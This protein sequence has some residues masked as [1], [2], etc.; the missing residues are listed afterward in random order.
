MINVVDQNDKPLYDKEFTFEYDGNTI[1]AV[2]DADGRITLQKV[3]NMVTVT[4]YQL[5]GEG[6]K[7]NVN[8]FVFNRSSRN[9]KIVIFVEPEPVPVVEPPKVEEPKV[10]NMRFKVIDEKGAVIKSAKVTI[11]YDGIKKELLTDSDGYVELQDVPV[12]AVVEAK[13]VK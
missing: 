13:A 5:N 3:R 6:V 11:K 8:T 10:R 2:S 9:Y 12:G 7:E 4:A 1:K